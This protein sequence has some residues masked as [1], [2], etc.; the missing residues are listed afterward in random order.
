MQLSAQL[1]KPNNSGVVRASA[2]HGTPDFV[3]LPGTAASSCSRRCYRVPYEST[4]KPAEP[5]ARPGRFALAG[6]RAL[7]QRTDAEKGSARGLVE[8]TRPSNKCNFR[9]F[10]ISQHGRARANHDAL[11]RQQFPRPRLPSC[12]APP[13]FFLFL[14]LL[15]AS[16][17]SSP[18]SCRSFHCGLRL[19]PLSL[20]LQ[21]SHRLCIPPALYI[22]HHLPRALCSLPRMDL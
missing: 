20:R 11:W 4:T 6:D 2:R 9:D 7:K 18:T 3:L 16:V 17:C 21:A 1:I 14:L 15:T 22:I 19:P 5:P 13:C 10:L 8:T 12:V